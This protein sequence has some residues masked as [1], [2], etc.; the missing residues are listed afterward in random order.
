MRLPDL[1]PAGSPRVAMP[2]PRGAGENPYV[3]RMGVPAK[4]Y[5]AQQGMG[6]RGQRTKSAPPLE[7]D[8]YDQTSGPQH[9][10]TSDGPGGGS[11]SARTHG[12]S[13]MRRSARGGSASASMGASPRS[14]AQSDAAM[15]LAQRTRLERLHDSYQAALSRETLLSEQYAK[16]LQAVKEKMQ[17][18]ATN[19]PVDRAVQEQSAMNRKRHKLERRVS[20]FE[21]RLNDLDTYNSKLVDMISAHPPAAPPK[22]RR[23]PPS[24]PTSLPPS[25]PARSAPSSPCPRPPPRPPR[26]RRA[27]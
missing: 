21:E 7:G 6:P 8:A 25:P 9:V 26:R 20:G 22:G 15:R 10:R 11:L 13:G 19:Q 3:P 4:R 16:E 23:A 24:A 17:N 18:L 12:E 1:D 2:T 5:G 27:S 14:A